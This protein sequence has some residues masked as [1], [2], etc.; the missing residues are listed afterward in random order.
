MGN[1]KWRPPHPAVPPP[2]P[3]ICPTGRQRY[4]SSRAAETAMS[5]V[6]IHAG[7]VVQRPR[8]D[9]CG[10][11]KGWHIEWHTPPGGGL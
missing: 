10:S 8:M 9:E 2:E 6:G 7:G 3:V 5:Q 4:A 1:K 11:C